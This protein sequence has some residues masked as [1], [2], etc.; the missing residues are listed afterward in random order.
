[1]DV[2]VFLPV[3][4]VSIV[5]SS[6]YVLYSLVYTHTTMAAIVSQRR[7][8]AQSMLGENERLEKR[9]RLYETLV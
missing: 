6:L 8:L 7:D 2:L 4:T 5:A 9:A 3:A 1:M